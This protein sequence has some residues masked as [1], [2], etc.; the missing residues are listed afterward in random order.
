MR[1]DDKKKTNRNPP[2][3]AAA[4]PLLGSD[5]ELDEID[6]LR[7]FEGDAPSQE[8][9]VVSLA[10]FGIPAK[11]AA[12]P[13]GSFAGAQI[14]P[15]PPE[16]K[17]LLEFKSGAPATQLTKTVTVIGRAQGVADVVVPDDGQVS[18]QHAVVVFAD[19]EF[20]LEDLESRNGTFL[21]G[22]RI[23]RVKLDMLAEFSIGSYVVRLRKL[24]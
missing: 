21:R 17:V 5:G 8:T 1:P 22:E 23:K 10:N 9:S 14:K 19:G 3:A 24:K 4:E 2:P 11:P 13:S 16:L 7:P 6:A 18:R 20:F 12:P 15:L